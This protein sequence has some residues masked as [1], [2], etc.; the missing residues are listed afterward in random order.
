MDSKTASNSQAQSRI[1][2]LKTY[3]QDIDSGK[4]EFTSER[5]DLEKQ[6]ATLTQEMDLA[7]QVRDQEA[8]DFEAAK[9]EMEKAIAAM[10]ESITVLEAGMTTSFLRKF[11]SAKMLSVR[12]GLK[13]ALEFGKGSLTSGDSKL[14]EDML[15]GDVPKPDWKKLNRKATFKSKY[16]GQSG[17]VVKTLKKLKGDFSQ[18]LEDAKKKEAD[19]VAQY[20]KLKGAKGTMLETAQTALIDM[21]SENG[22]RGLSKEESQGEVDALEQQVTD[23]KK[24]IEETE[25][26][27]TTKK[28]EFEERTKMRG[29]EIRGISEAMAVLHSD[30]A[31]DA[32]KTSYE[33]FVQVASSSRRKSSADAAKALRALAAASKDGRVSAL[34][35]LAGGARDMAGV[36][37]AIDK[38]VETLEAE[39][40][41]DLSTKESCEADTAKALQEARMTSLAVDDLTDDIG[42]AQDK[43]EELKSQIKE[44]NEFIEETKHELTELERQ[45]KDE[46]NEYLKSKA[47]DEAAVQLIGQAEAVIKKMQIGRA[48]V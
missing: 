34:A 2:S 8:A 26:A 7:Q 41:T 22:A 33:S 24:F 17:D 32:F 28:A 35:S 20:D 10:D 47:D 27:F 3:I 38:L 4:I 37:T 42:R 44:E 45:R 13:K 25:A 29:I 1:D 31:R 30:E 23:D 11:Q 15:H 46:H 36:I 6:V 12:W 39:E 16:E 19:A 5:Q 40:T 14:I 48:H 9:D 21:K 18:N 43:I